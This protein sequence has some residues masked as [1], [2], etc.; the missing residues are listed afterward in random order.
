MTS[1]YPF[2]TSLPASRPQV[3]KELIIGRSLPQKRGYWA[4]TRVRIPEAVVQS[5]TVEASFFM[6]L[7]WQAVEKEG[8]GL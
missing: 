5:L 3:D 4:Q 7:P 6:F 2:L 1:H 8:I